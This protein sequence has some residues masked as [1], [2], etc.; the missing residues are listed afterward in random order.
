MLQLKLIA[1]AKYY[2]IHHI[3]NELF[4]FLKERVI[5]RLITPTKKCLKFV[6]PD[7]QANQICLPRNSV[8]VGYL[9]SGFRPMRYFDMVVRTN[10][11]WGCGR[12][13]QSDLFAS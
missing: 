7:V 13:S 4:P 5:W 3:T 10:H 1:N 8:L 9:G 11:I 12:N 2:L 6:C